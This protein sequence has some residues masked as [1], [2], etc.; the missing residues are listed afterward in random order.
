MPRWLQACGSSGDPAEPLQTKAK[1]FGMFGV[2]TRL[3]CLE[4]SSFNNDGERPRAFVPHANRILSNPK[5]EM[6]P[7]PNLAEGYRKVGC[8][9]KPNPFGMATG[10]PGR[11]RKRFQGEVHAKVSDPRRADSVGLFECLAER[12]ALFVAHS[13]FPNQVL[14]TRPTFAQP[15]F[16]KA[17]AII[18]LVEM[19][20]F[21]NYDRSGLHIEG[22]LA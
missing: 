8:L 4:N 18:R 1:N 10:V 21:R 14:R 15:S 6:R 20:Q 12:G 19:E 13:Q 5:R 22:C 2:N 17:F 3:H 16:R 7:Y 11:Q 9:S